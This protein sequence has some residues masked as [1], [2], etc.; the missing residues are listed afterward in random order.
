MNNDKN[1]HYRYKKLNAQKYPSK[2]QI[3]FEKKKE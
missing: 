2:A 1:K 3:S